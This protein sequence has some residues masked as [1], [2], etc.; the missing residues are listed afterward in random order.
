MRGR[1]S[2]GWPAPAHAA[3]GARCAWGVASGGDRAGPRLSAG[4]VGG[5]RAQRLPGSEASYP[6]G[7]ASASR[8][9][10]DGAAALRWSRRRGDDARR[11]V[12]PAGI[13]W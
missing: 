1:S 6:S 4:R 7:L 8:Q 3:A 2:H 5:R 11:A 9:G 13:P 12:F 10:L